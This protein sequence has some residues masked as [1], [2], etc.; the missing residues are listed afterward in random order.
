MKPLLV[1]VLLS[2]G[3]NAFAAGSLTLT[4]E[5]Y[6]FEGEAGLL[7]DKSPEAQLELLA[8]KAPVIMQELVLQSGKVVDASALAGAYALQS[9]VLVEP[10]QEASALLHVDCSLSEK[11]MVNSTAIS[12]TQATS[13]KLALK[14][15]QKAVLSASSGKIDHDTT[16]YRVLVAQI[17]E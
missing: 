14:L 9:Q 15:G 8:D 5:V 6:R 17:A 4:L 3:L 2:L 12:T 1:I 10:V 13:T 11:I 7:T 16:T